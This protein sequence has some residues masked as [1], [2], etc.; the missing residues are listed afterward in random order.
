M[1]IWIFTHGLDVRIGGLARGIQILQPRNIGCRAK[2]VAEGQV[3]KVTDTNVMSF[4]QCCQHG[5][6]FLFEYLLVFCCILDLIALHHSRHMTQIRSPH[7]H[8]V[9]R[10][11]CNQ[12]LGGL[13]YVRHAVLA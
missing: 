9:L 5:W 8:H 2:F 4:G 12:R 6:Q 7:D 3:V 11:C 1:A 10:A 13:L